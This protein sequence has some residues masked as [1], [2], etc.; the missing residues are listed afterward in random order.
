MRAAAEDLIDKVQNEPE[1]KSDVTEILNGESGDE[2]WSL[3][4]LAA[5]LDD[6]VNQSATAA[7]PAFL[8]KYTFGLARAFSS[9]Y[10]RHPIIVEENYTKRAVLSCAADIVRI[11]LTSALAALGISVPERM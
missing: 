2:L 1:V 5:R 7:E 11:Q 10:N 3:V 4:T 8:A 6:V 9:F